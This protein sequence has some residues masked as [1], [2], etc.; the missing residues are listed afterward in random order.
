MIGT[1]G[2]GKTKLI[3]AIQHPHKIKEIARTYLIKETKPSEMPASERVIFQNHYWHLQIAEEYTHKKRGFLSDRSALDI[4]AYS[5]GFFKDSHIEQLK[6]EVIGRQII[7]AAK[8]NVSCQFKNVPNG[9]YAISL[10]HDENSNG[11]HDKNSLGI[12]NEGY[13]FSNNPK[14]R[15]GPPNLK[16]R[17]FKVVKNTEM[18]IKINYYW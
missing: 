2:V 4:I 5:I 9:S 7:S 15:F 6:K 3:N 14:A 11:A 1:H 16:E 8:V 12:P 13:G 18:E 10:F 17:L